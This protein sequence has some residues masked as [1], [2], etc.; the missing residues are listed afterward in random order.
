VPAFH[1]A[2]TAQPVPYT[3]IC[4]RAPLPV[5]VH[6]AYAGGH[7]PAVL[8]DILNGLTAPV[9]GIPGMPARAEQLASTNGSDDGA[10]GVRGDPPV[11]YFGAFIMHGGTLQPPAFDRVFRSMMALSLFTASGSAH[12]ASTPIQQALALYLLQQAHDTPDPRLVASGDPAVAAAAARLTVLPS[13]T[14]TAWLSTHLAAIRAGGLTPE[15]L[16]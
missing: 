12:R 16:P 11:L 2:T 4:T 6:P 8:S 5:C 10:Y 7:E 3:P 13:Q 14:R 9:L 15:E 1:A